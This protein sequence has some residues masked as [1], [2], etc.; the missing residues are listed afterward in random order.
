MTSNEE[1]DVTPATAVKWS[2]SSRRPP[3]RYLL[4]SN[5][6]V[7][8]NVIALPPLL[9]QELACCWDGARSVAQV[10]YSTTG[11]GWG[12]GKIGVVQVRGHHR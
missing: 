3:S 11:G 6:C 4:K 2:S 12:I 9:Q 1:K 7:K 5:Q 8:H 10:E